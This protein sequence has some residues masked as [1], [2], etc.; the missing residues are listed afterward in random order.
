[1]YWPFDSITSAM[2]M[3]FLAGATISCTASPTRPS[4]ISDAAATS[5]TAGGPGTVFHDPA[6]EFRQIIP[7]VILL[8]LG[9]STSVRVCFFRDTERPDIAAATTWSIGDPAVASVSP[10][11]GATTTVTARAVGTTTLTA[12]V[13]GAPVTGV[14]SVCDQRCP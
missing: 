7:D 2:F 9:S 4:G 3:T 5:C 8:N 13:N 12:V 6:P 10:A 11:V 14:I 1:M